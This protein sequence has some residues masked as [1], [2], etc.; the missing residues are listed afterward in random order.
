[1]IEVLHEFIDCP[2][3]KCLNQC[4]L[5]VKWRV[6]VHSVKMLLS[7]YSDNNDFIMSE[8][9]DSV[10]AVIILLLNAFEQSAI[11]M[12]LYVICNACIGY[13]VLVYRT[14]CID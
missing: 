4:T 14:R 10:G 13:F 6:V 8:T 9:N 2:R 3:Q 7:T 12:V 11:L 5:T 1:M